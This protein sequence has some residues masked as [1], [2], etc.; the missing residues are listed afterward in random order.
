[1]GAGGQILG[2]ELIVATQA[3]AQFEGDGDW[4]ELARAGL[5]E[6]MAD[7]RGG[8][9][10]GELEFFIAPRIVEKWILRFGTDTGLS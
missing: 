10:V 5:R 7:Q 8:K 4:R 2:A 9:T 6:E 1:M 3:D